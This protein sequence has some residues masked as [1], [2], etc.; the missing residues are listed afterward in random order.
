DLNDA[1]KAKLAESAEGVKK[2]NGLLE[3]ATA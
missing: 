3:E 1:E 2:T